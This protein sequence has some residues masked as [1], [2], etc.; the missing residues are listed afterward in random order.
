IATVLRAAWAILMG[1][2]SGGAKDVVFGS[3][4]HGRNA[5]LDGIETVMGP[6]IAAIPVRVRFDREEPVQKLLFRVQA[7]SSEMIPHEALGL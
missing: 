1:V 7:E 5:P 3:I 4:V 2:N 6:T